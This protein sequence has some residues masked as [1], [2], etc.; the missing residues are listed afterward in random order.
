MKLL[1]PAYMPSR[2]IP[3]LCSSKSTTS[4]FISGIN[5][6]PKSSPNQKKTHKSER[7]LCQECQ[8]KTTTTNKKLK[9]GLRLMPPSP[10]PYP[11]ITPVCPT[12]QKCKGCRGYQFHQIIRTLHQSC[13][14]KSHKL[15]K[16][17]RPRRAISKH[18]TKDLTKS[19][20]CSSTTWRSLPNQVLKR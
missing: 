2:R 5:T 11:S 7:R 3:V 20:F 14:M 8:C 4:P 1:I 15:S 6:P 18:S 19:N 13:W 17:Q 9:G 12:G 10:L 16:L